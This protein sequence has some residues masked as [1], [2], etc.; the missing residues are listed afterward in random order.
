GP[1]LDDACVV[2]AGGNIDY[3]GP[4]DRAP[5]PDQARI[6]DI[7]GKTILPGLID[8]HVHAGNI[9]LQMEDTARLSPAVY[10]HRVT[11]NLETAVDLGFT[12]L[13]D[14]AGLDWS[15]VDAV[16]QELINGPRLLLSVSPLTAT[17]G[18]FDMRGIYDKTV[19]ARNRLGI[20]P[21]ICDGPD[22]V[23]RAARDV[24]RRGAAQIKV[25]ADGGVDSPSD[26][27]GHWQ[28]SV[29][30]LAAAVEV[31]EA[32]GTYVMAHAY[33]PRAIENCLQAGVRSIEHGNLLDAST[34]RKMAAA[35]A[36]F[37]PTLTVYD[38]LAN[39]GRGGLAPYAAKKLDG[40]AQSGREAVRIAREAGVAIA[41]G[42]DIIG[43]YQ[44]LKG[45]ELRIKS[46][47]LS[48]MEA[49]VSATRTNARLLNMDD[50][51][52]TLAAGKEAD[53]I[54]MDGDPLADPTLFERG[55]E[56]V[57]MVVKA[58]RVMK[59]RLPRLAREG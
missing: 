49:I 29:T 18:H 3:A 43:P 44:E 31:A 55:R 7:A 4:R 52:G 34:A 6:V 28:F 24:L 54:I 37:V 12:T 33:T 46:E 47:L 40:V 35:G 51:I 30:E 10:V 59:D 2:V 11:H 17:G 36:F 58:G 45:R 38:V 42:S 50:R 19:V 23:R 39:E 9:A 48:P 53:L 57:L 25:A 15:F 32:A 56:T 5:I 13:R 16:D 1:A 27:P 20:C 22:A 14:A 21:E 41:S 26:Q 8:A